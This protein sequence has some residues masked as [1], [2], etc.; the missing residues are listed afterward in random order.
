MDIKVKKIIPTVFILLFHSI[1]FAKEPIELKI[2]EIENIGHVVVKPASEYLVNLEG[3]SIPKEANLIIFH[4]LNSPKSHY[5]FQEIKPG[6][7]LYKMNSNELKATHGTPFFKGLNV[8]NGAFLI[9]GSESYEGSINMGILYSNL[10]ISVI[11]RE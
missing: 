7:S 11:V 9:I 3:Y 1:S 5:Y 6:K 2:S 8:S 4:V 10:S